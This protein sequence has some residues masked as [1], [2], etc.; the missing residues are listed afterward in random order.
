MFQP[1]ISLIRGEPEFIRLNGNEALKE[2]EDWREIIHK[3]A[4]RPI[5]TRELIMDE[6]DY[7]GYTDSSLGG[8]GGV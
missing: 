4:K 3:S 1:L 8:A 5:H 7:V 6:P 2:L